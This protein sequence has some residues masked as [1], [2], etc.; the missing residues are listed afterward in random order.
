[1]TRHIFIDV[2]EDFSF[3]HTIYSHGWYDL[4]PFKIDTDSWTLSYVFRHE[5]GPVAASI[6]EQNGLIRMLPE[7]RGFDR[8]K[9]I[10]DVRHI[11]RLDED[12]SEFY[13]LIDPNSN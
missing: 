12:I 4:L 2:P 13:G 1:M 5:N 6:S 7:G 8:K 10:R 3:R 9:M 11:L